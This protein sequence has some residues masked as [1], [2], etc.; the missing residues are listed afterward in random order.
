MNQISPGL[1]LTTLAVF[2]VIMIGM[3]IKSR[4]SSDNLR[5]YAVGSLS[6]SPLT[7][8]LALASSL[9][10]A[11]TFIINPGFISLYGV[12]AYLAFG[13]VMPIS[14][15]VALVFLMKR[16]RKYGVR[17]GSL[18]IA[19]WMGKRFDSAFLQ[20]LFGALSILL[21][22]F[23]VLICVGITKVIAKAVGADELWVLIGLVAVVFTYIMFGGANSLVYTNS[24]QAVIMVVV[25]AIL[26]YSGA[27]KLFAAGEGNLFGRLAEI[28]PLLI[29]PF[30]AKSPLFRD[31]FEVVVC[32]ALIGVAIVCQPHILTKSLM[33]KKDSEVNRFLV[34]S[35]LL[36]VLFF[37]VVFVG[38][39]A[40][41]Y[42]PDLT[43]NGEALQMDGIIPAFV[44]SRFPGYISLLLIIGL[45]A[46]GLSTL[47]GLIQSVPTSMTNDLILPLMGR[48]SDHRS[49][50]RINR[51]LSVIIAIVVIFLSYQQL[52]SPN[53]SVA[54]FAQNGVYAFFSAAFV[55]VFFGIFTQVKNRVIPV[56]GTLTALAVYYS[57]YYLELTPYMQDIS[58]KNPAIASAFAL[59]IS[60]LVSGGIYLY[61]RVGVNKQ[62]LRESRP[63]E[64]VNN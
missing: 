32:N 15:F 30:N 25:A 20:K 24:V 34:Y 1:T 28:D 56:T 7:V 5:S 29:E 45:I 53:L 37:S 14:I 52:V 9:T 21:I 36:L 46:A 35:I 18:S 61:D 50:M 31:F 6:F 59:V 43:L 23:I 16:F 2:V 13:V 62:A 10:S 27:D 8:A 40:R 51:I 33:L 22:T 47:E 44:V 64:S 58:P 3:V 39:Y 41:E 17:V 48:D 57:V 63:V 19:D 55:P 38:F 4:T 49:A 42:F 12:A 54:I 26:L 60:F 11:A